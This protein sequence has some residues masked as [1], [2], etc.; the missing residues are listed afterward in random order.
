MALFWVCSDNSS[1]CIEMVSKEEILDKLANL[2]LKVVTEC[3]ECGRIT[4][5]GWVTKRHFEDYHK[6]D[7]CSSLDYK[8][9]SEVWEPL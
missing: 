5:Q 1:N 8:I 4:K 9:L 6:C 2:V 7:Y 3:S